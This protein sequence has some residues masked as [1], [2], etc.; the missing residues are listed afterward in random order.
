MVRGKEE[1]G[2]NEKRKN[3]KTKEMF[4]L[5]IEYFVYRREI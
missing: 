2:D 1:K 5:G 3:G 4:L